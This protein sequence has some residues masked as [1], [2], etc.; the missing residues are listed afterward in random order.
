MSAAA[1]ENVI[2]PKLCI[3]QSNEFQRNSENDSMKKI[4]E[5]TVKQ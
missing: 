2:Q 3:I 4:T 5:N 1:K